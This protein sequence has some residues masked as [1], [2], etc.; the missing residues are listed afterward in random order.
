[1]PDA[2]AVTRQVDRRPSDFELVAGDRIGRDRDALLARFIAG[3]DHPEDPQLRETARRAWRRL[4]AL[5]HDRVRAM[6]RLFRF[7]DRPGVR[8]PDEHVDDV[9]QEV[10][11]RILGMLDGFRGMTPEQLSAAIATATR[12]TCMDWCRREMGRERREVGSV[13]TTAGEPVGSC[14]SE[15]HGRLAAAEHHDRLAAREELDV[16]ARAIREL[17]SENQ[18]EVVRLTAIGYESDEIADALGLS[19]VNV[20]QLRS[21]ALRRLREQRDD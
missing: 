16:L 19:R 21:R 4:V 7:P 20:N 12:F 14:A 15:A 3:R 9:S 2:R 6:V 17:P 8:I 13:D 18:R 5:E 10:F 1:V 11:A